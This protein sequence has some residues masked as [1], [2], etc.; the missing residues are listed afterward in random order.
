MFVALTE[1]H[2]GPDEILNTWSDERL[3]VM[4]EER[5]AMIEAQKKAAEDAQ[6]KAG[7]NGSGGKKKISG[8]AWMAANG[9]RATRVGP[10]KKAKGKTDG[11]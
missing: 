6:A 10:E 3:A 8:A 1:W 9:V 7:P 2:V 4:F 5:E 11:D